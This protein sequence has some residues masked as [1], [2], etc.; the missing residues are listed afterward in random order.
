MKRE[1]ER[2]GRRQRDRR[3]GKN[4]YF[5][6]SHH[7]CCCT[8]RALTD[9]TKQRRNLSSK[10]LVERLTLGGLLISYRL[11]R[12]QLPRLPTILEKVMRVMLPYYFAVSMVI[13]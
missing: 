12:N 8:M 3:R 5:H 13:T 6:D 7:R 10:T 2:S 11:E 1:R 9:Q 4:Q